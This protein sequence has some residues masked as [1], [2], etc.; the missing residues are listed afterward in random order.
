MNKSINKLNTR[1]ACVDVVR[2]K[3]C[4]WRG[5][6]ARGLG[7][8]YYWTKNGNPFQFKKIAKNI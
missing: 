4:E 5:G 3:A 7:D 1:K 8:C 2:G 6:F